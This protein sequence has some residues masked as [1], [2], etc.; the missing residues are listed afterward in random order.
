MDFHQIKMRR[1]KQSRERKRRGA[2]PQRKC[3]RGRSKPG[4]GEG[5]K[6][7]RP[8]L[9]G[10]SESKT[11]E[12][13]SSIPGGKNGRGGIVEVKRKESAFLLSGRKLS[14]PLVKITDVAAGRNDK[15]SWKGKK[16]VLTHRRRK[17]EDAWP[18]PVRENCF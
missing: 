4:G 10:G 14:V 12:G 6:A 13:G 15:E 17:M 9:G 5:S 16:R 3:R 8:V 7:G 2:P 11:A 1:L 18:S